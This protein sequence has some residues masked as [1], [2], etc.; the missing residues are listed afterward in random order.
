MVMAILTVLGFGSVKVL[1]GALT[2]GGLV[3]FYTYGTR[4]FEPISSAMELYSRLQSVGA[5]IRRVRELLDLEP[6][7]RDTGR[8]RL[9]SAGLTHG[10]N[11]Q[12]VSFSY[13]RK[14]T[15]S[16]L[17]VQIGAGERV[18]SSARADP[19]RVPWRGF[20]C[21][22]QIQAVGASCSKIVRLANTSWPLSAGPSVLCLSTQCFSK[23][24]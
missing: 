13:G 19:A 12:D 10:F 14:V 5:S 3:A 11:I 1:S 8:E 23:G 4:V 6:T 22:L 9:E 21:A 16:N 2:I 17:T 24:L 20:L 7:V 18:A 15:L